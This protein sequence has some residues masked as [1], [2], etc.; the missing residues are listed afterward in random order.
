MSSMNLLGLILGS[1][2]IWERNV[3]HSSATV[4]LLAEGALFVSMFNDTFVE[5]MPS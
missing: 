3:S 5:N 2:A 4:E 1:E